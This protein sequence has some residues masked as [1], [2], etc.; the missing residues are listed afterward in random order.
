MTTALLAALLAAAVADRLG[1]ARPWAVAVVA[2]MLAVEPVAGIGAALAWWAMWQRRRARAR[3]RSAEAA[4]AEHLHLVQALL[5]GVSGGL[6]LAAALAATRPSLESALGAEIDALR[7]AAVSLG[8]GEALQ[9]AAGPSARLFHQLGAAHVSG[10]PM[11][12]ALT[13]VAREL[14]ESE[15]GA[16]VERARQLPVRMVVP[17]TLLMLPGFVLI[18]VGPTILSSVGRLLRPF[19]AP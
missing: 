8:L 18:T 12:L 6:S 19:G 17:L 10:A 9:A 4:A 11:V 14:H 16:A 1:S 13:A 7:R 15:R 3:R 5:I 2:G